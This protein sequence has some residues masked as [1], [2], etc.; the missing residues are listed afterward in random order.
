M[1]INPD[2]TEAPIPHNFSK[3]GDVLKS[4]IDSLPV[5]EP[6]PKTKIIE[7][8]TML[9]QKPKDKSDWVTSKK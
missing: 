5:K 2:S 1:S 6:T 9:N 4:D 3:E 7:A 8:I